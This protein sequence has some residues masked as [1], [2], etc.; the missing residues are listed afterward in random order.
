M[1]RFLVVILVLWLSALSG[2]WAQSWNQG[3]SSIWDDPVELP[4]TPDDWITL[5]ATFLRVHGPA[6]D[7][8]VLL[9]VA[10]H[11]SGALPRLATALDVP[12]G[13]TIHIYVASS[14]QQFRDLQNGRPPLWADA[15]AHPGQGTIF[16]RHPHLRKGN[17]ER[18][19]QVIDHELVHILVGRA[20]RP[21]RPPSWLQ[22]G[23]A[24][25]YARQTGPE[26]V[27]T[28]QRA[29]ATGG[30]RD[31]TSI[32]HGF[33][34]DPLQADT[35]YAVAADFIE[36]LRSEYGA[37]AIPKLIRASGRGADMSEAIR[38]ATGEDADVVMDA[39]RERWNTWSVS[40]TAFTEDTWLW[41]IGAVGLIIAGVSRRRRFARRLR[42]MGEEEAREE[43]ERLAFEQA[44]RART[45]E[46]TFQ[47]PVAPKEGPP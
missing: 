27:R 22:E 24:Q 41:M 20:F 31:L 44:L 3:D 15:T 30:F 12:I 6:R 28:I 34:S 4:L 14:Q 11:A 43:A 23:V 40:L 32:E 7:T 29:K 39:W 8:E 33:P 25:T 26:T 47:G 16:L 17:D 37:H 9:R 18:L 1:L 2:A 36:W 19:E 45:R 46:L 42:E 10:R 5:P 21:Q 35:A 13:D 38:H